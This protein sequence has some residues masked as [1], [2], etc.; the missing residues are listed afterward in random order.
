MWEIVG[1][2]KSSINMEYNIRLRDG[3]K[4][5]ICP[6]CGRK[7]FTPFV[8]SAGEIISSDVG[9]C[10]HQNSCGYFKS[11]K[12]YYRQNPDRQIYNATSAVKPVKQPE[13]SF[14]SSV[15]MLKSMG[16]LTGE[17]P[18]RNSLFTYLCNRFSG[19]M[20]AEEIAEVFNIYGVG[21]SKQFGGSPVFWL[22]DYYGRIRDGKVMGYDTQT[23][24]RI[25]TPYPLINNVHTLMKD[26]YNGTFKG[27]FFGSHL[28]QQDKGLPICLLESEKAVIIAEMTFRSNSIRMGIP[29]AS[30]GSDGFNPTESAIMKP[31][32]KIRVLKG[33]RVLLLPDE[34]KYQE[35]KNKAVRLRGYCSE[36]YISPIMEE[37]SRGNLACSVMAGDGFD[38]LILRYIEADKNL[39]HLIL[40]AI[41]IK[42]RII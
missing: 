41:R 35:W 13:L 23:G 14:I 26:K 11:P 30:G 33:R 28:A 3:G 27:C 24:K 38:D 31:N 19:L 18:Y 17:R 8:T 37:Q 39:W 2:L 25:K 9:R 20:T 21:T 6:K 36:V 5:D 1:N 34:G 12:E 15:D 4:K 42:E 7:S 32:D 22:I 29:M 10:D 16:G 40:S